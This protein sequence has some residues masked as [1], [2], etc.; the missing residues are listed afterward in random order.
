M[1]RIVA[2]RSWCDAKKSTAMPAF[3]LAGNMMQQFWKTNATFRERLKHI[4]SKLIED[5]IENPQMQIQAISNF[6]FRQSLTDIG[7]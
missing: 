4:D 5:Y 6:L 7:R 1:A 2:C 3:W